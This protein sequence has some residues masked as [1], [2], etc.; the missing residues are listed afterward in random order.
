ML[1]HV[2]RQLAVLSVELE[3]AKVNHAALDLF[4]CLKMDFHLDVLSMCLGQHIV[5]IVLLIDPFYIIA[6]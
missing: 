6:A 2:L 3:I 4:V 1:A 5:A